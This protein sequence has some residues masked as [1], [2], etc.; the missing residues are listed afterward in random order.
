MPVSNIERNLLCSILKFHVKK[1]RVEKFIRHDVVKFGCQRTFAALVNKQLWS[2][3]RLARNIC[4]EMLTYC[5]GLFVYQL[6]PS[7]RL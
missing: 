1:K 2:A 6:C 3:D 7:V 5:S 4:A